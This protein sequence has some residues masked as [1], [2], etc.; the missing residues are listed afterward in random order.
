MAIQLRYGFM[1][2]MANWRQYDRTA[3]RRYRTETT[4]GTEVGI[5]VE[6]DAGGSLVVRTETG[7]LVTVLSA[8]ATS[9]L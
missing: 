4:N 7:R 2:T 3:G 9:E 6:V 5:A 8:S 1:A